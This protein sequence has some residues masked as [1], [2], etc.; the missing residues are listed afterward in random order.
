MKHSVAAA[1]MI[2]AVSAMLAAAVAS[3]VSVLVWAIAGTAACSLS[4]AWNCCPQL[5]PHGAGAHPQ[6][7]L[8]PAPGLAACPA[9]PAAAVAA[10][11]ASVWPAGA[12]LMGSHLADLLRG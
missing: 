10:A 12:A 11:V 4:F 2:A 8:C 5:R 1:A 6:A 3:A 9:A 7:T